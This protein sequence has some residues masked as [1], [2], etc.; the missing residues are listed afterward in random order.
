MTDG[1]PAAGKAGLSREAILRAAVRLADAE[2]VDGVSM[3][4]LAEGFGATAMALYRH[5]ANKDDLLDGMVDLV[6]G[7]VETP[8]DV[9]WRAA[10]RQ[11]AASMRAALR[12]HP[13]AVDLMEA[14]QPGPA[15]LRYHNAGL[16]CLREAAGLPIRDAIDAYNLMDSYIYGFALQ[17]KTLPDDI[18][19]EA[20]ARRDTLTSA[21]PSLAEQFPYLI[22]VVDELATSGYDYTEQFERGLDVILDGIQQPGR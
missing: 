17:E 15:N 13:W 19:A 2:G 8:R 6:F 14:R 1:R 22:E 9:G 12:R 3:R 5:V 10:M 16:A 21:D 18:A 11:R 4:K 20:K 7:E